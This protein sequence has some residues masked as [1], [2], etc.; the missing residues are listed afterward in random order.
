MIFQ[1]LDRNTANGSKPVFK[2]I[3]ERLNWPEV[4]QEFEYLYNEIITIV[5]EQHPELKT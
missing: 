2:E 3:R 4:F 1:V 5:E